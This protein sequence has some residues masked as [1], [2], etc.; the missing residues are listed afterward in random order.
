[1]SHYPP[2]AEW[3][4]TSALILNGSYRCTGGAGEEDYAKN[5]DFPYVIDCSPPGATRSVG[6]WE[7]KWGR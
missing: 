7:W 1:M 6:K 4:L 5:D 2:L 3:F